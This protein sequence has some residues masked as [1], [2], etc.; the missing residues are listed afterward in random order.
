MTWTTTALAT[1]SID[2]TGDNV[3]A[4]LAQLKAAVDRVNELSAHPTANHIIAMGITA[5]EVIQFASYTLTTFASYAGSTGANQ[6]PVDDTI[7]QITEGGAV[8]SIAFTPK[9]ASSKVL[10]QV[11]GACNLNSSSGGANAVG[12]IFDGSANAIGAMVVNSINAAGDNVESFTLNAVVNAGSTSA[13]TYSF[14][15]GP[16]TSTSTLAFNGQSG[17]L[18]GGV[19]NLT[20]TV[21]EIL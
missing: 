2:S 7:P 15:A 16:S 10:I 8:C 13:R 9:S 17:R 6:I 11:S 5:N 21:T 4:G 1:T 14:R 18:L 20:M 3:G 12:A 19:F